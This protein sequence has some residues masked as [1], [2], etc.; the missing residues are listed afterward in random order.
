MGICIFWINMPHLSCDEEALVTLRK[1]VLNRYGQLYGYLKIEI[2]KALKERAQKLE[3]E[4]K[5]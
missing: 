1:A 3:R 4:G 5:Q 2:T